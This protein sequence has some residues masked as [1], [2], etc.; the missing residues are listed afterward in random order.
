MKILNW[1]LE[2]HVSQKEKNNRFYLW[3]SLEAKSE[4]KLWRH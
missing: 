3:L 2:L 1:K 4:Y